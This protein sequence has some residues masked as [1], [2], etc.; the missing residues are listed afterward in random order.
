MASKKGIAITAVIVAGIVGASVLVWMMPASGPARI[1]APMTDV[2]IISDIYSRHIDLAESVQSEFSG[3][4]NGTVST[5]QMLGRIDSALADTDQIQRDFQRKPA[6]DW[7][8]SYDLYARSLDSFEEYL[9]EMQSV[10]RAG[11]L[12]GPHEKL[13]A[14]KKEWQDYVEQSVAS[15]PANKSVTSG[16]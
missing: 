10:V 16:S 2:E 6:Q 1:D 8:Q 9:K 12:A 13:D 14:L 3:W 11:D 7:V 15:M 4:K 5:Q